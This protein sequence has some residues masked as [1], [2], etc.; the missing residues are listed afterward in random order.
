MI[1]YQFDCR[2][3][4]AFEA[5]FGSIAAYEKQA[6]SGLVVCPVCGTK[7]VEKSLAAPAVHGTRTSSRR[8]VKRESPVPAIYGPAP[9]HDKAREIIGEMRKLKTKLLEN[10]EN[11]GP[12]FAEEA[13]KIHFGDAPARAVHGEA[14][15]SDAHSLAEDGVPFGMIPKLPEDHN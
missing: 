1:K 4:H 10:S 9:D 15:L 5:W 7:K 12:R 2:K 13:R 6:A 11:V 3:G 14:T 8:K